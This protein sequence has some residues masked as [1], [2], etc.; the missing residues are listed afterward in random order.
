[1][2]EPPALQRL[3]EAV[4]ALALADDPAVR[5]LPDLPAVMAEMERIETRTRHSVW[6][7]Q[8][9]LPLSAIRL[10]RDLD[11]RS[12]AKGLA[13]RT[14]VSSAR[15]R[16]QPLL[17]TV[18]PDLRVGPV[19]RPV[20]V[21][22][23]RDVVLGSERAG[24][25]GAPWAWSSADPGVAA[26]AVA[27]FTEAWDTARRWEDA[28]LRPPLTRRRYEIALGMADGLTDREIAD[29]VAVS[30][31]TVAA[32]VREVVRWLGARNRSHAI[33]VLVGAS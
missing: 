15:A 11:E 13:E 16:S 4:E 27:A 21:A 10:A 23:G 33:A 6:S 8:R 18:A 32:E 5:V 9:D 31:R 19:A 30:P 17:T 25:A 24:D 29:A 3:V 20:L 14:I 2:T 12:G 1:M 28:G 22:D 7:M 26:L